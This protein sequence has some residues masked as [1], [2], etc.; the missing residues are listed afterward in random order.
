M[1]PS[2]FLSTNNI[3]TAAFPNYHH[4]L[5]IFFQLTRKMYKIVNFSYFDKHLLIH[6]YQTKICTSLFENLHTLLLEAWNWYAHSTWFWKRGIPQF[7]I[8]S[9]QP[10]SIHPHSMNLEK[11]RNCT[12][13]HKWKRTTVCN[14]EQKRG[15]KTMKI[16]QN[17]SNSEI[18]I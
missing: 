13:L 5:L 14:V 9:T 10:L 16:L 1:P 2:L 18:I 4:L 8:V 6:V 7:W 11:E 17:F 15:K 3:A 12:L